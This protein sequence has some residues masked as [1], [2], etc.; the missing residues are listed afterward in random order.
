[1]LQL[2]GNIEVIA[3]CEEQVATT[4]KGENIF[5]NLAKEGA[6]S[7]TELEIEAGAYSKT[8]C[9]FVQGHPEV[10]CQ[11]YKAWVSEKLRDQMEKVEKLTQSVTEKET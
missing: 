8:R 10:G 3:I 5:I 9:F 11:E 6:N 4:F 1:M 7:P 2:N